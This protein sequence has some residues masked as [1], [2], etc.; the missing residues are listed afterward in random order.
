MVAASGSFSGLAPRWGLSPLIAAWGQT[1]LV[2]GPETA[3]VGAM[4]WKVGAMASVMGLTDAEVRERRAKGLGHK[5]AAK[6]TRTFAQIVRNNLFTF[7]NMTL[8]SIGVVLIVMGQ[9]NDAIMSA[10][11]AVINA[12]IGIV[13]EARAKRR[14]DEIALLTRAKVNV[15]RDGVEA[16]I[17]P[18]EAVIGDVFRLR[19]GDQ[20]LMDGKVVGDD[21]LDVD[22][23]L[24]TGE[25]DAA[26]KKRGD[27]IFA[28]SFCVSGGGYY[29][30]EK[31][32]NESLAGSIASQARTFSVVLTPLQRGINLITRVLL[33]IVTFFL[34]LVLLGS[35]IHNN[36]WTGRLDLGGGGRRHHPLRALSDGDDHLFDGVGAARFEGRADPAGQRDRIAQQCR[37]CSAPTKPARSPPI[38]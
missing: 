34:I 9:T 13:Q 6:T 24:L 4:F 27:E 12:S 8:I 1:K 33:I 11:L 25:S 36:S 20:I 26:P 16:T 30:A 3:T 7:I 10:G 31:S 38:S 17:D 28:G 5:T 32:G 21:R 15:V 29:E 2:V 37:P 35:W 22:E 19:P 14:L 18:D 23:S